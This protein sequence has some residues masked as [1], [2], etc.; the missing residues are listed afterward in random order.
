MSEVD[1]IGGVRGE[2]L[3]VVKCET[4]DLV[5]PDTAEIV[6]EGIVLPNV[7]VPEGPFGEYLGYAA[8]PKG[9]L[10]PQ[11]QVKALYYRNDPI[12]TSSC[13]GVPVDDSHVALNISRCCDM[14]EVLKDAGLP[15][16]GV[17]CPPESC[18]GMAIVSVK[19]LIPTWH[20]KWQ[21]LSGQQE[22]PIR[23]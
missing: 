1:I 13:M 17:Y 7:R 8:S 15:V 11:F 20:L 10:S 19:P 6:Y 12:L 21:G 14:R 5:V 3:E 22:W 9:F 16:V 23:L 4:C 2:P 18:G